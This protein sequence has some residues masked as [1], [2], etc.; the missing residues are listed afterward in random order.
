MDDELALLLA[1]LKKSV[2]QRI[3][4]TVQLGANFTHSA[5]IAEVQQLIIAI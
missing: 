4:K 5:R 2:P 3:A 1:Q